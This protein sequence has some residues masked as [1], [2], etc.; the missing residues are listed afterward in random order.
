MLGFMQATLLNDKSYVEP[1]IF[2]R[3]G[4]PKEVGNLFRVYYRHEA[5]KALLPHSGCAGVLELCQ[6]MSLYLAWDG[7][8]LPQ[9]QAHT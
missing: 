7:A 8:R 6:V 4:S 2:C 5:I 9:I 3:N 1:A